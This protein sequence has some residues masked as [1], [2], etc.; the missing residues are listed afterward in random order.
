MIIKCSSLHIS[1]FRGIPEQNLDFFEG[2]PTYL[3]GANNS[4]KSTVLNA[5]ALA[6]NKGG[7]HK[8]R[9]EAFD[10]FVD[11]AGQKS[12]TFE[13]D[14]RFDAKD[15]SNLPAVQGVGDPVFVHG[16]LVDGYETASGGYSHRRR[17]YDENGEVIT[18]SPRTT[19]KGDK[20]KRFSGR[21]VGWGVKNARLFDIRDNLPD[22]WLLT[23]QNVSTSLY[24]WKTGPLQ[25]LSKMLS[26][27]FL[28]DSWAME[29]GGK[30]RDM[31]DTLTQVHSFLQS[32]VQEFPFWK[33]ELRP[34]MI[35]T[36][37][38]HL[39][40]HA[41][42]ELA[43]QVQTLEE[44]L[45]Q[46]LVM[47][48]SS[49]AGGALVPLDRMGD[50][51]QSLVRLA[52]LDVLRNYPNELSDRVVLLYEEPETFLHPHLRRKL[53]DVF[54]DLAS[55]GWTIVAATHAPEFISL[56]REQH[57]VRL[58]RRTDAVI[59]G[60]ILTQDIAEG[61]RFQELIDEHGNHEMFFSNQVILCEGKDD[62]PAIRDYLTKAG[63][64]LNARSVTLLGV[65]GRENLKHYAA[66]ASRLAIPWCAI[67]DEDVDPK[68]GD[69]DPNTAAT[70]TELGDLAGE[71]DLLS[72]WPG[73]LEAALSVPEGKKAQ[74]R[75]QGAHL[76][77]KTIEAIKTDYPGFAN[78]CQQIET[79]ITKA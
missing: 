25:T 75:W 33:E 70:R 18:F 5:I 11:A 60:A 79:W 57:I 23:A 78:V 61:P 65:G 67:T 1:K 29:Y 26:R 44:W 76:F 37:S 54:Q 58:H 13:I 72:M 32:S 51:W 68:T 47:S 52:A 14:I 22:V 66:M 45:A 30:E 6:F 21:G 41:E 77:P 4:S 10:F 46:Q 53:R 56:Q 49:D 69:V 50:G 55:Q 42:I 38:T 16:I 3:I 36:L 64:D 71:G 43:P 17:L 24:H 40:R 19:L 34:Q 2:V 27:R 15:E 63:V 7:F 35:D 9:P 62:V 28:E 12:D 59:K 73:S 20:K 39:G 31:P 8:F 74:P 48:F